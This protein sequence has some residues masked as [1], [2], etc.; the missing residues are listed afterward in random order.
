VYLR[1]LHRAEMDA[2]GYMGHVLCGGAEYEGAREQGKG[3]P[4]WK[5]RAVAS[6]EKATAEVATGTIGVLFSLFLFLFFVFFFVFF[7]FLL[8]CFFS[9]SLDSLFLARFTSVY[10]FFILIFSQ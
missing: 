9:S 7:F 1:Y 10:F 5:E 3:R 4:G 8:F 2:V 6:G